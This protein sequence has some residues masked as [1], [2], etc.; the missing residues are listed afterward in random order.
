[1]SGIK[2]ETDERFA[3]LEAQNAALCEAVASL[4]RGIRNFK[5][6]PLG[7]PENAA[8]GAI[9]ASVDAVPEPFIR[10]RH[11]TYPGPRETRLDTPP[12]SREA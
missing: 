4:E 3:T 12:E 7:R 6:I 8:L 2:S 9:V 5:P 11:N 10:P 1:M